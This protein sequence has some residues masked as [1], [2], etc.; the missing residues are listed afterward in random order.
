MSYVVLNI[1]IL[2][3]MVSKLL[4]YAILKWTICLPQR[5]DLVA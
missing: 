2:R 1:R 3:A 4:K 5:H